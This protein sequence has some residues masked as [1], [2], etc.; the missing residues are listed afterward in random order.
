MEKL[1]EREAA[2]ALLDLGL[3]VPVK[4]LRLPFRKKPLVIRIT[5]RRPYLGTQIR[6]AKRWLDTGTSYEELMKLD[7]QGQQLFLR[8]HGVSV[9]RI[10]ADTIWRGP[11]LGRI[12]NRPTAFII[13]HKVEEK[14]MLAALTQFALLADITGFANI[15]RLVQRMTPTMPR[16]SQ[17][18]KGS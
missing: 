1:V 12:L 13:R 7:K 15:I 4:V 11:V 2:E 3:S 8:K 9:S 17:Q 18:R 10:V 6:M 5:L 14:Y 16:M